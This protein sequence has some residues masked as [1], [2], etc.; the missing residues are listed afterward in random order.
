[1][2]STSNQK[3]I[4]VDLSSSSASDPYQQVLKVLLEDAECPSASVLETTP[5]KYSVP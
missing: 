1:M 2:L 4:S 5:V 3:L